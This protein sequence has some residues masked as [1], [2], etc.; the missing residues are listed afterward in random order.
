MYN[1]AV[2]LIDITPPIG[3]CKYRGCIKIM[4]VQVCDST[5]VFPKQSKYRVRII[6]WSD[7]FYLA[8]TILMLG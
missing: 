8:L 4:E 3:L 6:G 2:A 5:P 7:S 1:A